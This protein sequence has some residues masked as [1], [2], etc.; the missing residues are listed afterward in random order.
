MAQETMLLTPPNQSK[1]FIFNNILF[2]THLNGGTA[3]E[4]DADL[5]KEGLESSS[6]Y[7]T[8]LAWQTLA[9]FCWFGSEPAQPSPAQPSLIS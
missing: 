6:F 8:I 2:F 1:M 7:L 5:V 3:G 4:M 9:C